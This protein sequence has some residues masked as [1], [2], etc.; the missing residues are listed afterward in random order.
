MPQNLA[1]IP[2]RGGSKGIPGKNIKLMAGKPLIAWSIEQA[3]QSKCIERV[4][5]STDSIEI[6]KIAK[7]W[8]AEVP[9]MRPADLATD[10]ASTESCLLHAVSWLERE[11]SYQPDNIVLLQAT[12]PLRATGSI[13]AA[14]AQFES[15]KADSLLSV[16]PFWHFL[17]EKKDTPL[18]LY[19]YKKRPRRQDIA[20]D[21]VKY[22]ENGSIYI[23]KKDALIQSCNRL[24]GKI[25]LYVMDE[26][27]GFEIDTNI[28]WAIISALMFDA[29][30]TKNK[31]K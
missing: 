18:A 26:N 3:A 11:E 8:G 4:I 15:E 20:D 17:W 21:K 10:Q 31:Q 7:E 1:I 14:M 25:A 24:S 5:V 13:D 19:D 9:F 22:K 23:T 30:A 28:D 27:E 29:Q 2:A 12:S 6:A 16:C